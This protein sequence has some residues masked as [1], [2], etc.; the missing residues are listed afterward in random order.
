MR[1]GRK[2]T[3]PRAGSSGAVSTRPGAID[4]AGPRREQ[5]G[6]AIGADPR[7]ADLLALLEPGARLGSQREALGRPA[8]AHRRRRRRTRR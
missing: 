4:A 7:E 3:R 2:V 6:G 5:L 8:D 1:A